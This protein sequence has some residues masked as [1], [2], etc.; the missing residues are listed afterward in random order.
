MKSIYVKPTPQTRVKDAEGK[1]LP[2]IV[3]HPVT[4]RVIPAYGALVPLTTFVERALEARELQPATEAAV[5]A[6][7][8]RVRELAGRAT[9]QP[10]DAKAPKAK[11]S[12]KSTTEGAD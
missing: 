4:H 5:K 8:Q 3:R 10:E 1:P 2:R 6:G 7:D 12:A 11:P 9:P